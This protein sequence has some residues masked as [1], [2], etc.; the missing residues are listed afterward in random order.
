MPSKQSVLGGRKLILITSGYSGSRVVLLSFVRVSEN[1]IL[2]YRMIT[3]AFDFPGNAFPCTNSLSSPQRTYASVKVEHIVLEMCR[4]H[5][6]INQTEP[7][8]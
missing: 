6:G 1:E 5:D 3:W 2:R 4:L 7:L 8:S